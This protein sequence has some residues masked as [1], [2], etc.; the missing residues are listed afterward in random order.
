MAIPTMKQYL[1]FK[2]DCYY[3]CGGMYDFVG[4]FANLDDAIAALTTKNKTQKTWDYDN[5]WS[6]VWDSQSQGIVWTTGMLP[7]E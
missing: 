1:A 3:P 7:N 5:Q 2:G 6:H 4:D